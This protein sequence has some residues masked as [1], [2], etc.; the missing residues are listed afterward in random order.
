MPFNTARFNA[1]RYNAPPPVFGLPIDVESAIVAALKANADILSIVGDNVF[2][3]VIPQ[4]VSG[5]AVTYT[6]NEKPREMHLDGPSGIAALG[7]E[8]GCWSRVYAQVRALQ[9]GARRLFTP[10]PGLVPPALQFSGIQFIEILLQNE[11]HGFEPSPD[12]ADADQAKYVCRLDF[13]FRFR[14][15]PA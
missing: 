11:A 14:E 3:I 12:F 15:L 9:I 7:L 4:T 6:T 5:P 8:L 10:R 13:L 2:P 1:N